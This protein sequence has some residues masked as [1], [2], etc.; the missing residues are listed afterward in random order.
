MK[1]DADSLSMD[2]MAI[3]EIGYNSRSLAEEIHR[4]LNAPDKPVDVKSIALALDV[5]EIVEK[6]LTTFEGALLTDAERSSGS[7]LINSSSGPT[8]GRFT[9]AHEL[10]HFLNDRHVATEGG[11][12]CRKQDIG[13]KSIASKPG[14]ARHL[15]Q[16]TEANRFAIELLAPR[17]RFTSYMQRSIDLA[18][19]VELSSALDLSKEACA[20]RFVDLSSEPIAVVFSRNGRFRY[21]AKT[22]GFPWL[23]LRRESPM[24]IMMSSLRQNGLT[25]V[26]PGDPKDWFDGPPMGELNI[27]FLAQKKGYGMT[28]LTLNDFADPEED[29]PPIEDVFDRYTKWG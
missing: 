18:S 12:Q 9:I 4:Q 29:D 13:V 15:R 3:D 6:P 20:R 14:M 22:S 21:A 19:V 11:F 25:D 27:Q 23:S 2:R 1:V 10:L 24:P 8:R 7:I 5:I 16:E 17:F 26:E 28:L